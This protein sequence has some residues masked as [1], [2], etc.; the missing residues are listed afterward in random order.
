[1]YRKN[2]YHEKSFLA[3]WRLSQKANYIL[4]YHDFTK[5]Q[6]L[7]GKKSRVLSHR[8]H[9]GTP[10]FFKVWLIGRVSGKFVK[11][12]LIFPPYKKYLVPKFCEKFQCLAK[13]LAAWRFSFMI[14]GGCLVL[15]R[16]KR[17][18]KYCTV[19]HLSQ[20]NALLFWHFLYSVLY[21]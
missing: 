16:P 7:L 2:P 18:G 8:A 15:Y 1:M 19:A 13:P 17:G 6:I 10:T 4:V 21:H 3:R 11:V 5:L 14:E 12:R 9:R 20:K